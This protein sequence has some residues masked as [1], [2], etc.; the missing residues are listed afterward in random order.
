LRLRKIIFESTNINHTRFT[1]FLDFDGF[2]G[3]FG[4]YISPVLP[5]LPI[6]LASCFCWSN[7]LLAA[8]FASFYLLN[9]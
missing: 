4:L 3:E 1:I 6:T 5:S 8:Y 9:R 2:A 7:F